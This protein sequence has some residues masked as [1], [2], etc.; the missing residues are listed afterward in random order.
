MS[1][2]QWVS[3]SVSQITACRACFAAKNSE[4][5]KIRHHDQCTTTTLP[6]LHHK[7]LRHEKNSC[8][9]VKIWVPT[10]V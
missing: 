10:I 5:K 6:Q 7:K 3:Q 2:S 9:F 1:V 4:D 8:T